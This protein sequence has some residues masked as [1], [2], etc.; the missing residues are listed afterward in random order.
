M[1]EGSREDTGTASSNGIRLLRQQH[2]AT[3][4]PPGWPQKEAQC[5]FQEWQRMMQD[6]ICRQ[7]IWINSNPFSWWGAPL[8]CPSE[9]LCPQNGWSL[10]ASKTEMT[11][12]HQTGK[13]V[14]LVAGKARSIVPPRGT[15]ISWLWEHFWLLGLPDVFFADRKC[16][17]GLAILSFPLSKRISTGHGHTSSW[18]L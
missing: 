10:T 11:N 17:S 4:A 13:T 5:T 14:Y 9:Q 16:F 15:G 1:P 12:E 8:K 3:A 7:S 2:R 6:S 18:K